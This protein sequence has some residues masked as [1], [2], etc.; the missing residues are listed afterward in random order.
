MSSGPIG[1]D[2]A[3]HPDRK[4]FTAGHA[5]TLRSRSDASSSIPCSGPLSALPSVVDAAVITSFCRMAAAYSHVHFWPEGVALRRIDRRGRR[6]A[7]HHAYGTHPAEAAPLLDGRMLAATDREDLRP[8]RW[9]T[10]RWPRQLWKSTNVGPALLPATRCAAGDRGRRCRGR[11]T[12][13]GSSATRPR[14]SICRWRS[15]RRPRSTCCC[16]RSPIR[17]SS[18]PTCGRRCSR[19]TLISQC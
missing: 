14:T 17:T 19:P 7:G 5:P 8:W 2:T 12:R 4:H 11:R 13:T 18:P 6:P 1:F 15:T 9:S 3:G 10:G 16:E